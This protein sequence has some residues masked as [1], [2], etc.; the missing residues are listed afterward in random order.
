VI[1]DAASRRVD[2]TMTVIV[3]TFEWPQALDAVLRGLAGQSDSRF[4]V[5]VADDGSTRETLETVA[6]WESAFG[7]RLIH[8]W[9][10]DEGF[11]LA[12]V[13]NLGAAHARG[14]SL[15]FVDGDCIPRRHFVAAIRRAT[16]PGWFL[17]GTRL[18]LS[19][20]LSVAVM[21]DKMP[22]GSWSGPRLLAQ[23][24]G[25]VRGWR[26]LTP[27]DRRRTWRPRL[28]DFAPHGNSYGF[29]T[30]VS[31]ADFEAVNGFDLRFVGWGDQDVDLAVRLRRFGLRCGYAGPRSALLHLWH[32][33]HVPEDRPT[34]WLLQDTIESDRIE[35]ITGYREL[36]ESDAGVRA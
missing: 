24:R 8:A 20:S 3:S 35:A 16:M 9:Q 15:V 7:A 33:S 26:H 10:P 32:Q 13:R 12:R 11:R 18:Q 27:R 19:D 14:S 17:A 21:R 5:V 28:P 6:G 22:I 25:G 31:R 1:G 30:A 36:V 29:C 23:A 2:K 4:D 34:W